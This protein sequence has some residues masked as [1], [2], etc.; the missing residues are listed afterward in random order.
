MFLCRLLVRFECDKLFNDEQAD[1]ISNNKP[2][3]FGFNDT[4]SYEREC[5][6]DLASF[7]ITQS[8]VAARES[9]Y[10]K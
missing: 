6:L 5:D 4:K 1:G 10:M 8:H 7:Y 9:L 3:F 2:I